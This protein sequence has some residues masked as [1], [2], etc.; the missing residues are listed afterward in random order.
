M[1]EGKGPEVRCQ[2]SEIRGQGSESRGR[3]AGVRERRAEGGDQESGG[4][5]EVLIS[6]NTTS[7]LLANIEIAEIYTRHFYELYLETETLSMVLMPQLDTDNLI[8]KLRV[9]PIWWSA[10][11]SNS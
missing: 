9:T 4:S 8:Q 10:K 2:K 3:R 11:T 5:S 6:E 1:D 7:R